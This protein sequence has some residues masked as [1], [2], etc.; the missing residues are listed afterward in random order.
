MGLGYKAYTQ[1][2]KAY[3]KVIGAGATGIVSANVLAGGKLYEDYLLGTPVMTTNTLQNARFNVPANINL[4]INFAI[5]SDVFG[6]VMHRDAVAFPQG[7]NK[8][9][10]LI[11]NRTTNPK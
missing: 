7:F 3:V 6:L 8:F 10:T 9:T 5:P 2:T 11:D 1:L 4:D